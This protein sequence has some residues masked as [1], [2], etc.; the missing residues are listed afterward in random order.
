MP[1]TPLLPPHSHCSPHSTWQAH[2]CQDHDCFS[3]QTK[4]VFPQEH[5]QA[6][7]AS[8]ASILSTDM[9]PVWDTGGT[10]LLHQFSC[11]VV[12]I[13]HTGILSHHTWASLRGCSSSVCRNG[14]L[15]SWESRGFFK[16]R[17]F[18]TKKNPPALARWLRWMEHQLYTKKFPVSFP[19]E[20]HIGGNQSML[21]SP[22]L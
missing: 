4:W 5:E 6:F 14:P 19:V 20:T 9:T 7:L 17:N 1:D 22:S 12:P 8:A 16:S 21:L 13:A 3:K 2:T 11:L 15:W 10:Y 18:K